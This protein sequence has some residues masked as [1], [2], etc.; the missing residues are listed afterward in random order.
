MNTA[1][2]APYVVG[3]DLGTTNSAVAYV[4]SADPACRVRTLKIPQWVAPNTLEA[5]ETLPSFYYQPAADEWPGD[6]LLLP[7]D[8]PGT[9]SPVTGVLAREYGAVSPG[10]LCASAKSWLCH[11]GVDRTAAL[12]P[13]YG[14]PDV[15]R[16]SPVEVSALYLA[17][18]RN[19]WN[20]ARP[21]APLERQ[22]VILTVPASFDAVARE[23]TVEAATRAGLPHVVLIEEP[24]AAFYAWL[25]HHGDAPGDALQAG[26]TILVC[27]VGGGTTDFTLIELR[28]DGDGQLRYHRTAVGD[29]LILGGDNLDLALAHHLESR[30]TGG[31]PLA[32]RLWSVLVRKC[33]Q[34]KELLLG[35][36]PPEQVPLSLPAGG[37]RVIAG[38]LT[39]VLSR[40]EAEEVLVE[41]FLPQVAITDQPARHASGVR[42]FGLPYAADAAITRYLAEFLT[43]QQLVNAAAPALPD[44]VLLNGGFFAARALRERL[45]QVLRAWPG[46]G[47]DRPRLLANE[48]LDLAVCHGA[49]YY[50]MV[51]RG[52]GM[53]I[54]AGVARSYYVGVSQAET[55]QPLA[56]CLVPT[57]LQEGE[58]VGITDRHFTLRIRQ[59]VEFPI[60]VSSTRTTDHPG[61]VMPVDDAYLHALPPVRTQLRSGKKKQ[62]AAVPVY[63][64]AG[65][66][67]VGT[68]DLR[69]REVQG[70]RSWRL[71]FDV[72][73]ALDTGV[74]PDRAQSSGHVDEKTIERCAA[75]LH[76]TFGPSGKR[77]SPEQLMKGL[78]G[79]AGMDRY[80]WPTSLLRAMWGNLWELEPGRQYSLQHEARWLNLLGFT[81]RPGY[82]YAVDD[83]RVEQTFRIHQQHLVFPKNDMCRA[84]WW[85]LWRRIA[86]GLRAGQQH[87]LAAP[88]L[89]AL[90]SQ[91]S[92]STK[93]DLH[94][95]I[96]S[97]AEIWRLLGALEHL[98]LP[99]KTW[100]GDLAA[101]NITRQGPAALSGA[102]VWALARLGARVP[103][104]GPLNCVVPLE[105]AE[106]WLDGL[107]AY[108]KDA[109]NLCFAVMQLARKT[110]DRFRDVSPACRE[111]VLAWFEHVAGPEHYHHLVCESGRLETEEQDRVFGERLPAGLIMR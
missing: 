91:Q 67:E 34:A 80:A 60:Y 59:P 52:Q 16:R 7:W 92:G 53:R 45:L 97:L 36:D 26:Q 9:P 22:E 104:Y 106:R 107:L 5:L 50:G 95:G 79:I 11:R 75:L 4:D 54:Q 63:L 78:E 62:A 70:T 87:T 1:E 2:K 109:D 31:A 85:V 39:A 66:T 44:Y 28:H 46:G 58:E 101:E 48:R 41:G 82:G 19:A 23:L 61:D 83:W 13:W 32:P 42:E 81:L 8:A 6:Q 73:S 27:D 96:D 99:A 111:R 30:F 71:Q 43:S 77:A 51:R 37:S 90:R 108:E 40:Q 64:F 56:V 93:R 21:Q 105:D 65:L 69:C 55:R 25:H 15:T 76:D 74:I 86:G 94:I 102:W 89:A 14:S 84:Q 20:A 33:Q 98:E 10:R 88:L 57:G 103:A 72:R 17:H 49:A 24:Q 18:I 3:I 100:L 38:A 35:Q 47:P 29:H 110:G 12:L 68:L